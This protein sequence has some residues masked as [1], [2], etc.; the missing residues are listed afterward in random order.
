[1]KSPWLKRRILAFLIDRAIILILGLYPLW[2]AELRIRL[3]PWYTN[4]VFPPFLLFT[5]P[6]VYL[7]YVLLLEGLWEGQTVGKKLLGLRVVKHGRPI[8]LRDSVKRNLLRL[9]DAFPAGL[10]LVGFYFMKKKGRR[11]GD[12][13]ADTEVV[14]HPVPLLKSL[15]PS[16]AWLRPVLGFLVACIVLPVFLQSL[17]WEGRQMPSLLKLKGIVLNPLE[18]ENAYD[19]L[20][21]ALKK[22]G[23]NAVRLSWEWSERS[24]ARKLHEAGFHVLLGTGEGWSIRKSPEDAKEMVAQLENLENLWW[25]IGNEDYS[26]NLSSPREHLRGIN[27]TFK[28][29]SRHPTFHAGHMVLHAPD[30]LFL[31]YRGFGPVD[32]TDVLG[33]NAYPP[34][35]AA[36]WTGLVKMWWEDTRTNPVYQTLL[37][38]GMRTYLWME[39][40]LIEPV[41][42]NTFGYAYL[43]NSYLQYGK[44]K[45]KPV[46]ITEW[47]GGGFEFASG[48]W[49][50]LRNFPELVGTFFYS[51]NEVDQNRDGTPDVP[52]LY[53]FLSRV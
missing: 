1:M 18:G 53:D 23:F 5:L 9:V 17:L 27:S 20:I 28:G 19:Q 24:I 39:S 6:A 42:T 2:F 49:R 15:S 29:E 41:K 38:I 4:P 47:G 51:W 50:I 33:F 44:L 10:Y 35:E 16:K 30:L 45:G 48:Q 46:V 21:P 3:G 12:L 11:L 36:S 34:L 13:Y 7:F 22:A 52:D 26:P 37:D 31:R 32:F 43:V 25:G 14:F 40:W 8:G